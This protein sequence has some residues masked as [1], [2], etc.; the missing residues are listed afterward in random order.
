MTVLNALKEDTAPKRAY[1][2][3]MECVIKDSSA[4]LDHTNLIKNCA[5]L[6]V[7]AMQD[8]LLG[9]AALR[10]DIIAKLEEEIYTLAISVIQENPV[11]VRLLLRLREDVM[12]DFIVP[13]VQKLLKKW[14]ASQGI[15][16]QQ[17]H[18][19]QFHAV[20]G[21]ITHIISKQP[22][23]NALQGFTVIL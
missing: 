8:L 14:H 6:V 23:S 9:K 17:T 20:S 5:E 18:L 15:I 2:P 1:L 21:F 16:A 10:E 22:A 19:T 12:K 7:T 3:Q 4:L 13:E 11:L